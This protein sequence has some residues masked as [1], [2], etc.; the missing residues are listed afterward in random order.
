M[1][2]VRIT[3]LLF[4]TGLIKINDGLTSGKARIEEAVETADGTGKTP[5]II[6]ART[7]SENPVT[8]MRGFRLRRGRRRFCIPAFS[9]SIPDAR[10]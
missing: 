5:T 4:G 8:G 9:G 3:S 7:G 1:I 6:V 10:I 2:F